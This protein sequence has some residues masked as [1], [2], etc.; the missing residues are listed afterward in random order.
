MDVTIYFYNQ[1]R[2]NPWQM[3][4][5][6]F[7]ITGDPGSWSITKMDTLTKNNQENHDKISQEWCDDR[8][9]WKSMLPCI[10]KILGEAQP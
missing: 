6:Q 4:P 10:F 1:G 2:E 5:D 7:E 9:S 3:T 8:A